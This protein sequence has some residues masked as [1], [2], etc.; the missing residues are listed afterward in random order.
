MRRN[1]GC[2]LYQLY[3]QMVRHRELE[4]SWFFNIKLNNM[5]AWVL[6]DIEDD[7]V[8]TKVAKLCKQA[9]LYRVQFS[10][11]LGT[12]DANGK[13][14]LQLQISGLIDEEKDSV[15]IF[16]MTKAELQA[17]ALLGKAFDKKL[18]TDDVKALFL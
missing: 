18:V 3:R 2:L 8:R 14:T 6:Y 16:P 9:G 4:R 15:Y 10:V 12:I 5:V 1:K 17:T 13:D 11:F 7:K